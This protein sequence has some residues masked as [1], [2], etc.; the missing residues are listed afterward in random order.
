MKMPFYPDIVINELL[1]ERENETVKE[2]LRLLKDNIE[3]RD[4]NIDCSCPQEYINADIIL[5]IKELYK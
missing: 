5:K 3:K 4:K 2:I 1:A